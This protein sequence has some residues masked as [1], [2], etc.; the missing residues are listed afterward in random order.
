MQEFMEKAKMEKIPR[1]EYEEWIRKSMPADLYETV[2]ARYGEFPGKTFCTPDG[3]LA[4]G[5]LRFGNIVL[6]PQSI[7]GE[8]EDT[9]KV[10]HGVKM[11]PPHPYI[12]TYLWIRHKFDADALIHFGT[13]GSLEFTPWKQVALSSYDWPDVLI[14]EM[15]HYYLY[16]MNDMGEAQIAKRRSYAALIS[17]LTAPFMYAGCCGRRSCRNAS[18]CRPCRLRRPP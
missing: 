7:S 16:M 18:S 3:K 4:L 13:H 15:P 6:M 2:T 10:V 1:E 9:D 11:A 5:M 17:H 8:G 12:A 14:G